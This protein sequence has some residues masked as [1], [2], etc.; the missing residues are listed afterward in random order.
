MGCDVVFSINIKKNEINISNDLINAIAYGLN[1]DSESAISFLKHW[2]R[3]NYLLEERQKKKIHI[4]IFDSLKY[5]MNK[6]NEHINNVGKVHLPDLGTY[7][8]QNAIHMLGDDLINKAA[9]GELITEED[10]TIRT[11]EIYEEMLT[12]T[13][14]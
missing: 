10:I 13:R 7:M 2:F 3:K 11:E 1:V 4:R 12:I 9:D 8:H 6:F 14:S 5:F